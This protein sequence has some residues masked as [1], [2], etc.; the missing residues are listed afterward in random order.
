MLFHTHIVIGIV[1]FLFT[2]S[3]V[4]GGN[5]IV[6]FFLVLLGSILPDIDERNS[7]INKWSGIIGVVVAALFKHRG[8]FHSVLLHGVL[9]L[10][11]QSFFGIYYAGG[12]FFGYIAHII[13]DGVT[14][15][16]VPIFYPFSNFKLRGPVRVGGAIE[17]IILVGLLVFV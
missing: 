12:L 4:S 13:G 16:G 5:E 1:V 3:F 15:M 7:K 9:F 10:V 14:R 11:I 6:F 17:S 2:R 8:L